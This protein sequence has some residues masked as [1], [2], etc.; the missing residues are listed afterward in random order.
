MLQLQHVY[1][2][3]DGSGAGKSIIARRIAA[4]HGLRVYSTDGMMANKI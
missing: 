4:Q 2:I 3:G 1:W